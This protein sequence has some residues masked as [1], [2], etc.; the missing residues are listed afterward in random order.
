MLERFLKHSREIDYHRFVSLCYEMVLGR[1]ADEYG[2]KM[3]VEQLE[4]GSIDLIGFLEALRGSDEF[5]ARSEPYDFKNDEVIKAF[6][7]KDV[8]D[9]SENLEKSRPISFEEYSENFDSLFEKSAETLIIG[10]KE[11]GQVHKNR[12]YELIN[13]LHILGL[14]KDGTSLLEFGASEFSAMYG[15]FFSDSLLDIADRP[16]PEDYVGFTGKVALGRLGAKNYFTI[17]LNQPGLF[18]EYV[19][20]FPRYSYVVFCEVLEHLVVNPVEVFRFLIDLLRDDGLVY[21]TTPNFFSYKNLQIMKSW[22]NPQ[23][24][25]PTMNGNWDAH[26]H[27]REFSL[28]ELLRFTELSGGVVKAFYHSQCW[29]SESSE[30]EVLHKCPAMRGNLVLVFGKKLG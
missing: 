8:V 3:Y 20:M 11:Y 28:K 12:F 24:I 5:A 23:E 25:Y 7:T 26:Y 1:K 29:D 4:S 17:D 21:L 30:S 6:L 9:L 15:R 16:V 18:L 19:K 13:A 10:Q 22:E 27:H 14:N 2:L